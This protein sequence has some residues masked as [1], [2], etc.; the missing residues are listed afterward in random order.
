MGEP[1]LALARQTVYP[2]GIAHERN[3]AQPVVVKLGPAVVRSSATLELKVI[4]ADGS[5]EII[6]PDTP[7]RQA[8]ALATV[9]G[10][11]MFGGWIAELTT[12]GLGYVVIGALAGGWAGVRLWNRWVSEFTGGD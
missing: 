12:G 9:L 10:C 6:V 4:R 1:Q 2:I 7:E 3:I 5:T 11:T 8:D